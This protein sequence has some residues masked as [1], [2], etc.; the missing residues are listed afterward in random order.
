MDTVVG[1]TVEM[2]IG[3]WLWFVFLVGLGAGYILN[4]MLRSLN[5]WADKPSAD[6]NKEKNI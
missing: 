3:G 1:F 4:N 6:S 2:Q 5:E